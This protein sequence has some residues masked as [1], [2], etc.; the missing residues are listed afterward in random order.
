MQK[1]RQDTRPMFQFTITVQSTLTVC[2]CHHSFWIGTKGMGGGLSIVGFLWI[3][4]VL[5]VVTSHRVLREQWI[6]AK[7]EWKEF[8]EPGKQS[9]Y[10]NGNNSSRECIPTEIFFLVLG[11]NQDHA[12]HMLGQFARSYS[13][14][15]IAV[16]W[17]FTSQGILPV[18]L[19][20]WWEN[21][22]WDNFPSAT[23]QLVNKTVFEP[24]L[25][26]C[27]F[28]FLLLNAKLELAKQFIHYALITRAPSRPSIFSLSACGWE[29]A[30]G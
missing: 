30:H 26:F 22:I 28:K 21:L 19:L 7:Y 14:G 4:T 16:F 20:E 11:S 15:A 29:I 27:F 23:K 25:C 2:K 12:A 17:H 13:M 10:S 3:V 5:L 18:I 8:T 24:G 9:S 1:P 6:R